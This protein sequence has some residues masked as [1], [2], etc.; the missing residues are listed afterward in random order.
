VTPA[1][2]RLRA[3]RDADRRPP[4]RRTKSSSGPSRADRAPAA[5]PDPDLLGDELVLAPAHLSP[6]EKSPSYFRR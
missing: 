3:E 4:R 6:I 5:P 2:G 1:R